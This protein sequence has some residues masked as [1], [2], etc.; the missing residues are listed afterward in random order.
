MRDP[1]ED[2][3]K[4]KPSTGV[5]NDPDE[6]G[7]E[8]REEVFLG[9]SAGTGTSRLPVGET[10]EKQAGK[11]KK[12]GK[13]GD[14]DGDSEGCSDDSEKSAENAKS[15]REL[16]NLARALLPRIK[17]MLRVERERRVSF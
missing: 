9:M 12:G 13:D 16:D 2:E 1:T 5:S 6:S 4:P 14:G 3:P 17:R 10:S 8:A 7:D 11:A 15:G